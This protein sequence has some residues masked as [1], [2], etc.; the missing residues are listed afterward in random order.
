[1]NFEEKLSSVIKNA[2]K[3]HERLLVGLKGG[4]EA[5]GF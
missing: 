4:V 2:N 5:G 3:K 1:M